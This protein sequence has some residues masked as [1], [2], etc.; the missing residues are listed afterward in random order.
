MAPSIT[1]AELQ[2]R[3]DAANASG[4]LPQTPTDSKAGSWLQDQQGKWDQTAASLYQNTH[5]KPQPTTDAGGTF[6]VGASA[7][8]DDLSFLTGTGDTA[9]ATNEAAQVAAGETTVE[10]RATELQEDGG[11]GIVDAPKNKPQLPPG[12]ENIYRLTLRPKPGRENQIY[13]QPGVDTILAPLHSQG[14]SNGVIFPYTPL[15][16]SNFTVEYGQ[17]SPVHSIMDF[18]A[19]KRTPAPT[20]NISGQFSAQNTKEAEYCLAVIHFFRTVTKMYFGQG[21]NIGLAPPILHL[22]GYG[23][24]M[25]NNLPV[26]V[27]NYSIEFPNNVDYV[28][29]FSGGTQRAKDAEKAAGLSPDEIKLRQ[30]AALTLGRQSPFLSD[31]TN[32]R[33]ADF[34]S[35][36][37]ADLK[38]DQQ[39][40]EA[41]GE[42]ARGTGGIAYI[43]SLFTIIVTL[44]VQHTPKQTREFNLD[45]FRR[46]E[47]LTKSAWPNPKGG[48]W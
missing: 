2:A 36:T 19:Y 39:I 9:T 12:N 45:S 29:V 43:P 38:K 8:S 31:E 25:F 6:D 23:N 34:A 3:L 21:S 16:N 32:K 42:A 44:V 33:G 40:K 7:Q 22:N 5:G 35:K 46:G 15:I 30:Q 1:T 13:G 24:M 41:A 18:Y 26:L 37:L 48:W 4:A 27:T 20:L 10:S 14:G 28:K 11:G 17:Y 47:L